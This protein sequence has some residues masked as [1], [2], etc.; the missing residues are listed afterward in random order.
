MEPPP[1]LLDDDYALVLVTPTLAVMPR[2][3]WL[4]VLPDYLVHEYGVDEQVVDQDGDCAT[5]LH[6][7]RMTATVRGE[8]RSGMFVISDVWRRRDRRWLLWRRHS[9]NTIVH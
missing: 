5:V 1:R 9:A 6:R 2:A 4:E 8:D 7:A 3:R